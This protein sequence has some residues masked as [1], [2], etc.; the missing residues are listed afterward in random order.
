MAV[1]ITKYFFFFLKVSTRYY[2]NNIV[3][4]NCTRK[5]ARAKLRGKRVMM[6][7]II[8]VNILHSTFYPRAVVLFFEI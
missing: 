6:L 4:C 7:L 1:R 2:Y 5:T 8:P 3:A